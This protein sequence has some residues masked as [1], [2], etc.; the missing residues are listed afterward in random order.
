ML[1]QR[2]H[3]LT[4]WLKAMVLLGAQRSC[5][6]WH[7]LAGSQNRRKPANSDWPSRDSCGQAAAVKLPCD[8]QLTRKILES[9]KGIL[10]SFIFIAGNPSSLNKHLR[11]CNKKSFT[12]FFKLNFEFISIALV[13]QFV[14]IKEKCS[15]CLF[16]EKIV[17]LCNINLLQFISNQ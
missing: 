9:V 13:F 1:D 8:I 14:L 3:Y 7:V 11:I 2:L 17:L 10:V 15:Y 4:T 6:F 5:L 12:H 16:I